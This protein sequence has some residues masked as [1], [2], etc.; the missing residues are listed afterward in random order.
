MANTISFKK[1]IDSLFAAFMG[2]VLVL[3]FT[4]HAGIGISPDSIV[5]TSAARALNEG[6]GF[7]QFDNT[8]LIIFPVFYP[9]FLGVIQFIIR[10]DVIQSAPY[11]NAFIFATVIFI[12]GCMLETVNHTKWLKW[13]ILS[14]IAFSPGLL[15]I[16]S[17]LWSET[18][19]IAE[20][21]IF[22]WLCK[23][24]F[25]AYSLKH[26]ILLGLITAITCD[27]RY[28]GISVVATG[29]IL[30]L[31][32]HDRKW[33]QKIIH[34]LMYGSI[35]ISFLTIN[36][37]RNHLATKTLTGDRQIGI[38]PL[39]KNIEYYGTVLSDW[40]PFSTFMHRFP[41]TVGLTFFIAV[42]LIFIY[43][44][45]KKIEHN[46]FE[47]IA[48]TFTLMYS[49]FMITTATLS[50][51]EPINSRLLSPF[52]I[53]CLFTVSFYTVHYIGY[54][55]KFKIK[56]GI[57]LMVSAFG[58][59]ILYQYIN[60]DKETYADESENGIGGYSEDEWMKAPLVKFIQKDSSVFNTGLPVYSNSS[61]GVYFF[62]RRNLPTFPER[63]HAKDVARFYSYPKTILIWFNNEGNDD[64]LNLKEVNA[65]KKLTVMHHFSDGD[66][67]LCE[68]DPLIH[69]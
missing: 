40:L 43:R 45:I 3:L 4:H 22:V 32:D 20:I 54:I 30:I 14:L 34:G 9:G 29:G 27:T 33:K 42:L 68:S 6:K 28:A 31:V 66:I 35:A 17:M 49:I 39:I 41:V 62:T 67:F 57:S 56:F 37:I 46:S 2:A 51:Y 61:H 52:Y 55:K 12:S 21:L 60:N 48:A 38:T 1:N 63:V 23:K 58:L 15:E 11:L 53:P 19:F 16:Y 47:K 64:I 5:Y 44:T 59:I 50:R 8:P 7:T 18:L 24:Y 36:L 10:V 13:I 26:L 25:S 69:K 65:K